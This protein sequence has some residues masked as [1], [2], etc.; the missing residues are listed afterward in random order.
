MRRLA[1]LLLV[2]LVI[3]SV[4]DLVLLANDKTGSDKQKK[5]GGAV[6]WVREDRKC[7]VYEGMWMI[8]PLPPFV[9][10]VYTIKQGTEIHCYA[11]GNEQCIATPCTT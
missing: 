4:T 8:S 9:T 2:I 3:L 7:Q 6:L 1:L 11:G 5:G 10:F